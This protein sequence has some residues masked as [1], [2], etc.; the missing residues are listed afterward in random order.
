MFHLFRHRSISPTQLYQVRDRLH[1]GRTVNVAGP[2][3]AATVAAWLADL[4]VNSPLVEQ[5]ARAAR[6]GDWAVAHAIGEH[7][8]VDISYV[9]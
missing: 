7:L 3:I 9:A 6:L 1:E 8:S 2:E 5:F 4:D